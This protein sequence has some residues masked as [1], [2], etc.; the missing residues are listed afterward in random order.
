MKDITERTAVETRQRERANR[1]FERDEKATDLAQRKTTDLAESKA[2]ERAEHRIKYSRTQESLERAQQPARTQLQTQQEATTRSEKEKERVQTRQPDKVMTQAITGLGQESVS[3]RTQIPQVTMQQ[4]QQQDTTHDT[5]LQSSASVQNSVSDQSS[6]GSVG[7]VGLVGTAES[8]SQSTEKQFR[9]ACTTRSTQDTDSDRIAGTQNTSAQ[10]IGS[11]ST[12]TQEIKSAQ[13]G[14]QR[15]KTAQNPTQ[16]GTQEIMKAQ[17]GMQNGTQGIISAQN[18]GSDRNSRN[19]AIKSAQEGTHQIR[20]QKG[21]QKGTQNDT[22]KGTQKG[23]QEIVSAQGGTQGITSGK[24]SHTRLIEISGKDSH[25]RLIDTSEHDQ[26]IGSQSIGYQKISYQNVTQV[27]IGSQQQAQLQ[28]SAQQNHVNKDQAQLSA[29]NILY[30]PGYRF[31]SHSRI[32]TSL[33]RYL[34]C[35]AILLGGCYGLLSAAHGLRTKSQPVGI[36]ISKSFSFKVFAEPA[37][38]AMATVD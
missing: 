2:A 23:T 37:I 8:K 27:I 1:D 34:H 35:V 11:C 18:I 14:T 25:T 20:A 33:A 31:H 12:G 6:V 22:Q 5:V 24:D 9:I 32:E 7:S 30:D 4:Q 36:L 38:A 29:Q 16:N 28:V 19:Q 26:S 17:N 13:E 3:A 21:T 10:N 15:N